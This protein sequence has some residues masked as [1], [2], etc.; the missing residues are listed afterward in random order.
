MDKKMIIAAAMLGLAMPEV[1]ADA[2]RLPQPER[3]PDFREPRGR[4]RGRLRSKRM[5]RNRIEAYK[6][7]R[8]ANRDRRRL[9]AIRAR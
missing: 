9:E 3:L 2:L 5:K 1:S 7:Q 4:D 8:A 6:R